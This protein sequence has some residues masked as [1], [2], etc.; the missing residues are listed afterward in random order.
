MKRFARPVIA[1][2]KLFPGREAGSMLAGQWR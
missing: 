2:R 1:I